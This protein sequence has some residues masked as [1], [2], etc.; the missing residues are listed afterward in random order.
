MVPKQKE[1]MLSTVTASSSIFDS[2][3]GLGFIYISCWSFF[4]LKDNKQQTSKISKKKCP[5]VF[6]VMRQE[7][8]MPVWGLGEFEIYSLIQIIYQ[9]NILSMLSGT[10]VFIC[11]PGFVMVKALVGLHFFFKSNDYFSQLSF[12]TLMW[13]DPGPDYPMD[14]LRTGLGA[15]DT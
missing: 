2:C 9:N 8:G 6:W 13:N 5:H 15:H 3:M 12:E 14:M 4:L 11:R 10:C 7:S 1:R